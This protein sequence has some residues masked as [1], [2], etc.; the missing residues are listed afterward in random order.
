MIKKYF[1]NYKIT[2]RFIIIFGVI[3]GLVTAIVAS[4]PA[5]K[6]TSFSDISVY[7]ECWILFAMFIITNSKSSK[8]A[9]RNTFLFFLI[10]QPL[11]YLF[12]SIFCGF[13]FSVFRFYPRWFFITILTIP[14]AIIAYQIKRKDFLSVFVLCVA[15]I[16][17]AY[18]SVYYLRSV[19]NNFPHHLLSSIFCVTLAIFLTFVIFNE[20]KYRLV[21]IAV[22]IVAWI[23]SSL[24]LGI[25]NQS[26]S[27]EIQLEDG[28]WNYKIE[29]DDVF[30]VN[31]KD[32]NVVEIK[33]LKNGFGS[34]FFIRDDDYTI[35]YCIDINGSNIFY[36]IP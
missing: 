10:S 8:E 12:E 7:V 5:L 18:Q 33:K 6:E 24:L 27:I 16:Y 4:I 19:I 17:L 31:M 35:E 13:D 30:S 22:I 11:V 36:S 14:G 1:G 34:V 23:T 26:A 3:T 9:A 32:E 29:G 21:C 2:N 20:R 28:N 15:N 25:Y